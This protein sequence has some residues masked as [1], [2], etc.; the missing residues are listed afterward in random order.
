M[1]FPNFP[2]VNLEAVLGLG[3][4]VLAAA[5]PIIAFLVEYGVPKSTAAIIVVVVL[6]LVLAWWSWAAHTDVAKVVAA[7][8]VPGV[9]PIQIDTA[10][11]TP[12]SPGVVAIAH[13]DATP[14]VKAST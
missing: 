6:V 7:S 3:R 5:V 10:P 9:Q 13:S 8:K 14:N 2:T 11:G 4:V 1:N 12:A